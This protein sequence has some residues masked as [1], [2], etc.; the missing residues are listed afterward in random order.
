MDEKKRAKKKETKRTKE[1]LFSG[2]ID[3]ASGDRILDSPIQ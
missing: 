1:F 3:S 2:Y